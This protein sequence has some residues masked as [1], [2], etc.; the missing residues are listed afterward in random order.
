MEYSAYASMGDT[1][2]YKAT[3]PARYKKL[4]ILRDRLLSCGIC[5]LN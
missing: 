1:E 4:S 2:K 3:S 5:F